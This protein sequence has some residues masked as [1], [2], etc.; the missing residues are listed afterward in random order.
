M[1]AD[2]PPE[3]SPSIDDRD[4]KLPSMNLSNDMNS[5]M[6]DVSNVACQMV[7]F[8]RLHCLKMSHVFHIILCGTVIFLLSSDVCAHA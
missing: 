6:C 4:A 2:D 5:P 3:E 8:S 1:L 7:H